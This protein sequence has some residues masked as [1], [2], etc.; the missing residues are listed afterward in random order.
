MLFSVSKKL[1]SINLFF[2]TF[3]VIGVL[4]LI[5]FNNLLNTYWTSSYLFILLKK[6]FEICLILSLV[7]SYFSPI[8]CN[9]R[10]VPLSPK[11]QLITSE[12]LLKEMSEIFSFWII[13]SLN[14]SSKFNL[15]F[16]FFLIKKRLVYFFIFCSFQSSIL[17]SN[18]ISW[19]F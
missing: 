16:F 10:K 7:T 8:S 5:Y 18:L 15:K 1:L 13:F 14:I 4:L 19:F 2:K 3:S 11:R 9:D 12:Y 6:S 17:D